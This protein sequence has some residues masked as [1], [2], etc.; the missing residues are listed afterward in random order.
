MNKFIFLILIIII[1]LNCSSTLN[2]ER[3]NLIC[4]EKDKEYAEIWDNYSDHAEA[5][6]FI[7]WIEVRRHT[8]FV[9]YG[10]YYRNS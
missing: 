7:N 2:V 1:T 3:S 5:Y 6:E 4:Y 8:F 9:G 10:K